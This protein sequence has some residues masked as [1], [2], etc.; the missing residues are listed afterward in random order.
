ME[1]T[2]EA[3]ALRENGIVEITLALAPNDATRAF[4]YDG[5]HLRFRMTVGSALEMELETHNE[6]LSISMGLLLAAGEQQEFRLGYFVHGSHEDYRS[7]LGYA[8]LNGGR[9][10]Q[11]AEFCS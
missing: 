11:F 4:G 5:F 6:G 7:L 8:M 2:I 1:W 3:T 10:Q 9:V